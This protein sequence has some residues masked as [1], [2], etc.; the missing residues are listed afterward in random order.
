MSPWRLRPIEPFDVGYS[1]VSVP[2]SAMREPA[3]LDEPWAALRFDG[4][5]A[6]YEALEALDEPAVA[7][8]TLDWAWWI[9]N[10]GE[11]AATA[12]VALE[13]PGAAAL[14]VCPVWAQRGRG[15]RAL[16]H[17]PLV[18]E[19]CVRRWAP[20]MD[21]LELAARGQEL[22]GRTVSVTLPP[23]GGAKLLAR[24]KVGPAPARARLRVNGETLEER[25]L[26]PLPGLKL[27][28]APGDWGFYYG[29]VPGGTGRY[30]VSEARFAADLARIG[31]LGARTLVLPL[32][33]TGLRSRLAQLARAGL[34]RLVV[35][36]EAAARPEAIAEAQAAAGRLGLALD[37]MT[38]DEPHDSPAASEAHH[39]AARRIHGAG[40]RTATAASWA[41]AEEAR[42]LDDPIVSLWSVPPG[43]ALFRQPAW[44]ARFYYWQ[45]AF[46]RPVA[47]RFLAGLFWRL[48][49]ARAPVP[50]T[51]ADAFQTEGLSPFLSDVSPL[52]DFKLRNH[53]MA[54][55]GEG[56]PV[57]TVELAG[58]RRGVDD[59]R[60]LECLR[61]ARPA[62]AAA[63]EGQWRARL[64]PALD[65]PALQDLY[66][67]IAAR[68]LMDEAGQ[69]SQIQWGP[70]SAAGLRRAR[71]AM[72]DL[73]ASP[74]A[75]AEP[76]PPPSGWEAASVRYE[77]P[78]G[79]V[80]ASPPGEPL[81]N[82]PLALVEGFPE[83]ASL[84]ARGRA[85]FGEDY[86]RVTRYTLRTDA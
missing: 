14:W 85:L 15:V 11:A 62:A 3:H 83:N 50:Y 86:P 45:A 81:R 46:A 51:W 13:A 63:F 17:G 32:A 47:N 8:E 75:F 74:A 35:S 34:K 27:P 66:N 33:A 12:E 24:V 19:L 43:P 37:W 44:K 21:G 68:P 49:G 18:A 78:D 53:F 59:A 2:Q 31:A 6:A 16:S 22:P 4:A 41:Y 7:G 61:R 69:A 28:E 10:A 55:P 64:G 5:A 67:G 84:E 52:Y 26:R 36:G 20:E 39:R 65:G 38:A 56:G 23:G 82:Y 70:V 54:Y 30:G 42:D 40:G 80:T 58:L 79:A 1:R 48:T 71:R 9:E 57:E 60:L 72:L 25:R 29:L 76:E 73:L 77:P